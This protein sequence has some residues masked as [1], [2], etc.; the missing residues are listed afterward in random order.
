MQLLIKKM[1]KKGDGVLHVTI[2]KQIGIICGSGVSGLAA[3][4]AFS[5]QGHDVIGQSVAF[6]WAPNRSYQGVKTQ[7]PKDLSID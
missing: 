2:K 5:A 7:A 1:E 6:G 3:A 4:K